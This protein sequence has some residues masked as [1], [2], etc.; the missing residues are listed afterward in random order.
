MKRTHLLSHVIAGIA[1]T[2]GVGL[3]L[4]TA[5]IHA[6]QAFFDASEQ[7][8]P[9][10]PAT[11]TG[12]NSPPVITTTQLPTAYVNIPYVA[13]ITA[14]DKNASD[15]LTMSL[16]NLPQ[17]LR[18][19]ACEQ[20]TQTGNAY[21]TCNLVGSAVSTGSYQVKVRVMDD[22]GHLEVKFLTL[23]VQQ[24]PRKQ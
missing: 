1:V 8:T 20:T 13:K 14:V 4:M 19:G 6:T 5:G 10:T 21:L 11:P 24:S 22:R 16:E 18:L 3:G 15:T 17:G 7:M 23:I 9:V 2:T 12:I